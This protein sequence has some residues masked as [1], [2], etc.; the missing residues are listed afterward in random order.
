LHTSSE[1]GRY[2]TLITQSTPSAT[3]LQP[4]VTCRILSIPSDWSC[5]S[6]SAVL[7]ALFI[8]DSL[9]PNLIVNLAGSFRQ[10][11][12]TQQG[13]KTMSRNSI[14]GRVVLIAGGAKNLGELLAEDL[15]ARWSTSP[16]LPP[17][18]RS[19]YSFLAMMT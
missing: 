7:N 2:P 13:I 18:N 9:Q 3:I 16:A 5:F 17:R 15:A 19:R 6:N 12:N 10:S 14:E 11:K 8:Q 1:S 4:I